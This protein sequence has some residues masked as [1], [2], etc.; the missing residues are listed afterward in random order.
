MLGRLAGF[1]VVLGFC[2][3]SYGEIL[4]Y[5]YTITRTNYE[6]TDGEW[7]VETKTYKGYMALDIDYDDYSVTEGAQI[8]YW[9]DHGE[10]LY[11][12]GQLPFELVRVPYGNK[13]Q[14]VIIGKSVESDGEEI[15]RI[16]FGMMAGQARTRGIGADAAHEVPSTLAGYSLRDDLDAVDAD[17]DIEM[18]SKLSLTLYPAWTYWA[19]GDEEDEGNQDLA[20]TMQMIKNSLDAKGY[21][22]Q[23]EP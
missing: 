20:L 12:Q 11:E 2:L 3:P 14:W 10:K 18:A 16:S 4:V 21:A 9:I 5:K 8:R 15:T 22:E 13:V 17:R 7:E 6:Q 1:L 23:P 19:N